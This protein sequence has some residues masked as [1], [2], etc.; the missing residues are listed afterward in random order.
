MNRERAETFLRLLAEAE[1]RAPQTRQPQARR[2][3]DAPLIT[4]PVKVARVAWALVAVGAIEGET[5]E[6]ILS[7]VEMALAA[8]LL[9]EHGPSLTDPVWPSGPVAQRFPL[10]R[11]RVYRAKPAW[12]PV[13]APSSAVTGS[14]GARAAM[15]PWGR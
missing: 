4:L 12:V 8:R 14:A 13:P 6:T 1:I 15:C 9:P 3:P 10:L 2:S 7:D 5:V 11:P